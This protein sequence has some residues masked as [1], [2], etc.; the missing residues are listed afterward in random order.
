MVFPANIGPKI[1]W[2]SPEGDRKAIGGE[3]NLDRGKEERI[4]GGG[5]EGGKCNGEDALLNIQFVGMRA[6]Q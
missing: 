5:G 1:T 4:Y 2:I 3:S 6:R